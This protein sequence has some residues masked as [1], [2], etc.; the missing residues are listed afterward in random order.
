ML[1]FRAASVAL[2]ALP[3]EEDAALTFACVA[4]PRA[5]LRLPDSCED[6]EPFDGTQDVRKES[7]RGRSVCVC[8]IVVEQSLRYERERAG[9]PAPGDCEGVWQ[10]FRSDHTILMA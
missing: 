10:I 7:V 3:V 4:L 6:N 8:A 5:N 2:A 1:A 9:G